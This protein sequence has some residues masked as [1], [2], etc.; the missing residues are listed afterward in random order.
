MAFGDTDLEFVY[1]PIL[2]GSYRTDDLGPC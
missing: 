2:T 1:A